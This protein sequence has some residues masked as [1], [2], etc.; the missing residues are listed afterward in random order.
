MFDKRYP[1]KLTTDFSQI[2]LAGVLSQ[3]VPNKQE[4]M[5]ERFLGC[6]ARKTTNY[7]NNYGS[8]KGELAAL[9]FSIRKFEHLLRYNKFLVETD[10]QALKYLQL[11]K[12]P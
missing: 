4:Q 8:V 11:I 2:A 3:E 9:I 1:F 10:A 7:E 6:A 5:E 12:E